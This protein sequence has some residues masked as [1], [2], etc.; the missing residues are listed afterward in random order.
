MDFM[1]KILCL[2]F[3]Q[4]TVYTIWQMAV[5]TITGNEASTL[6]QWFFTLWGLEVGLLMLKKILDARCGQG[7]NPNEYEN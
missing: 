6:T 2:A 7:G 4:I 1:K 5:F 3:G